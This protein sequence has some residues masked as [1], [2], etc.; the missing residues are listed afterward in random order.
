MARSKASRANHRGWLQRESKRVKLVDHILTVEVKS[1]RGLK[2][3]D[4]RART[5]TR[6]LIVPARPGATKEDLIWL[7]KHRGYDDLPKKE[8]YAVDMVVFADYHAKH[9]TKYAHADAKITIAEGPRTCG[10]K[11]KL[12]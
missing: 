1:P 9:R 7:V 4:G 2:G 8:R 3:T 12:R 6:D 5:T 10:R 11:I